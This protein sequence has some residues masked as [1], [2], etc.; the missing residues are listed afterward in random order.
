MGRALRARQ[1]RDSEDHELRETNRRNPNQADRP[2]IVDIVLSHRRAIELDDGVRVRVVL[3]RTPRL[4]D[5][6]VP[7]DFSRK[8]RRIS[9]PGHGIP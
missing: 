1:L 8:C 6:D 5:S 9:D 7:V 4:A 3:Q 2:A